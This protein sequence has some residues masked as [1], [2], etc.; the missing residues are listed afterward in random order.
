MRVGVA[1]LGEA[2][3]W[4]GGSATRARKKTKNQIQ[5]LLLLP[6]PFH[7]LRTDN[8]WL[9]MGVGLWLSKSPTKTG[10]RPLIRSG[11]RSR[12]LGVADHPP[13]VDRTVCIAREHPGVFKFLPGRGNLV[14]PATGHSS[15]VRKGSRLVLHQKITPRRD[16]SYMR[17]SM[18]VQKPRAQHAFREDRR[19]F[20]QS[21]TSET[22]VA[23]PSRRTPSRLTANFA[24]Y[25][26]TYDRL[27]LRDTA[28]SSRTIPLG[29]AI[30][31]GTLRSA[32]GAVVISPFGKF[33]V[34]TP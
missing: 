18:S 29:D 13:A 23:C 16:D 8:L 12:S 21:P 11:G 26:Q 2:D 30:G 10:C 25:P 34:A 24:G 3:G 9:K 14:R 19:P 6:L 22:L 5:I 33:T 28:I 20:I 17:Q 15:D 7:L 1:E 32:S 4:P 27:P 31:P